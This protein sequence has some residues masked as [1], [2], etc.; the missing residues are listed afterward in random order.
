VERF[1]KGLVFKAQRLLCHSTLGSR[2][3]KKKKKGLTNSHPEWQVKCNPSTAVDEVHIAEAS[4]FP[5]YNTNAP[6]LLVWS[7]CVVIFVVQKQ[8]INTCADIDMENGNIRT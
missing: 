8:I 5:I 4:H 3:I 7:N 1:R 2:V 6:L